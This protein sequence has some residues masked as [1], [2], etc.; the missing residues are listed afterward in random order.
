MTPT[1]TYDDGGAT[2][3]SGLVGPVER[4]V[5]IGAG[6]A[7]LTAAN[8]LHHGGI[9]SVV[10]EARDRLGG[11]LHTADV[12][13]S[14]VDLGGSW[15]HTPIGNPMTAWAD[16]CG[17]ERRPA[18]VLLGM[19]GWDAARG[20]IDQATYQRLMTESWEALPAIQDAGARLGPDTTVA[21]AMDAYLAERGGDPMELDWYRSIVR[22]VIEQDSAAPAASMPAAQP[23]SNT[24]EYDGDYV[25]D[26]LLGGYVRLIEPMAAGLDI[27]REWIVESVE[28][29]PAG[30]IVTSADGR[31]E[32]GSHVI[33]TLPLGVLQAGSVRFVPDLPADRLAAIDRLGMGQFEKVALR[34][35]RPFWSEAGVPHVFDV[36][37]GVGPRVV[38]VIGLDSSIGEPVAV[39]FANGSSVGALTT[40]T[41]TESA[42]QVIRILE[43]ATGVTAPAPTAI[44]RTAWGA[45]PLARGAYAYVKLGSTLGDLDTLGLPVAGRIL[46]AGEATSSARCGFADGALTSG[47]REAK[48]LL[49]R[50]SVELGV[51]EPG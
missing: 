33:V 38:L 18:N 51:I 35:E 34:F 5:I 2:I 44:A 4:V 23:E 13:G 22:A 43:S 40:G 50:E 30:V 46:F 15:I 36:S 21:E 48:R 20:L 41:P 37:P 42:R 29:G 27:R 24:L 9:P 17:V 6:M 14:P 19:V 39:G 11:R 47:I 10:L 49:R 16:Q 3:P 31:T 8:A 45:D 25:G 1:R 12:G 32:T 28:M 26:M 7:G